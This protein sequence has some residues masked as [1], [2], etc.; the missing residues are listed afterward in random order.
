M[1]LGQKVTLF[2]L[3]VFGFMLLCGLIRFLFKMLVD[4]YVARRAKDLVESLF[5]TQTQLLEAK[6]LIKAREQRIA[7]EETR[8]RN[9]LNQ[10]GQAKKAVNDLDRQNRVLTME[11]HYLQEEVKQLRAGG[12][13]SKGGN[14]YTNNSAPPPPPQP[15]FNRD[16]INRL[17]RLC[18][19]DRHANSEAAVKM[20]QK[21]MSMRS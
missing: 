15:V 20:T 19:P 16:E 18:H 8:Y 9:A 11:K 10:A 7:F 3:A 1:L 5:S 13:N 17:I 6:G 12:K 14:P 2:L 21:L 4:Y